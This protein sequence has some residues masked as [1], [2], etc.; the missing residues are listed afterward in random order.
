L[1]QEGQQRKRKGWEIERKNIF[2]CMTDESPKY[3][4]RE[5]AEERKMMA[6]FRCRN[7]ER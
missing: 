6:R 5:S 1:E 4:E 3:L 2:F 7:E